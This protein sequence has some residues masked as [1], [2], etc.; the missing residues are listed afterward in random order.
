WG[1]PETMSLEDIPVP[2]PGAG[3][4][5]IR[6]RA[7]GLNFFDI[8]QVQGKYQIK[9]PFPFT[10]GAE[11]A[12]IVDAVGPGVPE[13]Q[14]GEPVLSITHGGGLAEY[15]LSRA[16]TTFPIPGFMDVAVAAALPIVYHTS[17]FALRDRASVQPGEWLLVHAGAS[18]VGVSAIQLGRAFGARVIATAGEAEKL[19][20]AKAQGAEHV[21]SYRDESWVEQVGQL[22]GGRGADVIY[23]PVGGDVFDLSTKCIAPGGRLLVIGFASGRIPSIA[24]NRILLKNISIVGA[25]WGGHA[26]AHPEYLGQAQRALTDLYSKS[27]IRPPRPIEYSLDQAP[28]ALRDLANRKVLWKAVVTM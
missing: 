23:D 10:P 9:P 18:G 11:V 25:L 21:F 24:A 5:R 12:G 16:E 7:A 6:N 22:T 8:L 15:A 20:F 19:E 28:A 1:E 17:Y 27:E 14:I 4:V 3:Q 13:F 2:E 26:L